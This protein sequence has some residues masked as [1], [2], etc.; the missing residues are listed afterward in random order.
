M[1]CALCIAEGHRST[2]EILNSPT[3]CMVI[4]QFYDE[5]GQLHIHDPNTGGTYYECSRGH[6]WAEQRLCPAII[7]IGSIQERCPHGNEMGRGGY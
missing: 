4:T 2:I 7:Q 5:H 6:R 1:R 3:T